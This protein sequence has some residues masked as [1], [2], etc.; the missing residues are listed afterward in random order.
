MSNISTSQA[1]IIAQNLTLGTK[2]TDAWKSTLEPILDLFVTTSKKCPQDLNEF[3]K[4]FQIV[5]Q[6]LRHDPDGFIQLLKFHRLIKNGNGIKWLYYLC[7]IVLKIENPLLYEQVVTWSWEYPK[8]LLNLHRLTNMYDPIVSS[9]GETILMKNSSNRTKGS[10]GAKTHAFELQNK[11][12]RF[13]PTVNLQ[14]EIVLYT[15]EVLKLFKN[16]ITPG[17][18]ES[19]NPMFLKYMGYETGHWA[20]E[21]KL[22][23]NHLEDLIKLDYNFVNL[24]SLTD[25]LST[26]LGTEL[27]DLLFKSHLIGGNIFTNKTR[28]L[29]KKCFNSHLNLLDN[30]FKGV[31]QDGSLFGSTGLGEEHEIS[32]VC[33][34][35][36]KSATLAYDRFEKTVKGYSHDGFNEKSTIKPTQQV[37]L[38]KSYLTKGY[39]KYLELLKSCK[40][41]VKTTGLD[42]SQQVWQFFMSNKSFDQSIES[43]LQELA[44]KLRQSL[45]DVAGIEMFAEL[46]SKFELVLDISGS[47]QGTPIQT[48]LLYMLLMTKVF[49]VN[50]LY[51]F[52]SDLKIVNLNKDDLNGTMCGLVRKIYKNTTGATQLNS[53]FEYFKNESINNKNVII[54]TD[55]DC[56]P[57]SYSNSESSSSNP[58]HSAPKSS[59]GLKYIV[60]N[61]KET[62]MNFPYLK[63]DPDVCYV[64]GNNPKT[65]DGLFKALIKSLVENIPLNPSLVLKCSLDLDELTHGFVLGSFTKI[66]DSDEILKIHQVFIR[67]I[68]SKNIHNKSNTLHSPVHN[69]RG[70]DLDLDLDFD[71]DSD[72]QTD[73][74][75]DLDFDENEKVPTANTIKALKG[76]NGRL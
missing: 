24:I 4:I 67:N 34:Q 1:L 46:A 40:A 56:D 18:T 9:S 19:V 39:T 8:D 3:T 76:P 63:M 65:L 57:I 45:V 48:G 5:S 15:R 74:N 21:S 23:W 33:S 20:L 49:G 35:I 71:S 50:I 7:L 31:H 12:K 6:S 42:A 69:W 32:L 41:I 11:V 13:V 29:I 72:I 59:Q 68:T 44:T 25:E 2:G 66:F 30:L 62:K 53:V 75:V 60:V 64:T 73:T 61:V 14:Y 16:L 51:Y 47:M 38:V 22:I 37:N 43:K 28:R 52:E 26:I 27:R 58:F 17:F 10:I 70:L 55:G 54:I 36:K